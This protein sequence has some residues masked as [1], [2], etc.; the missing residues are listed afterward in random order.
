MKVRRTLRVAG[1]NVVLLVAGVVLTAA[2]LEVRL[3]L[4]V[5][6]MS[7]HTP[8]R[9]VSGVGLVRPPDAEIRYTNGLDFWTVSRTNRW[10]FL[11]REPLGLDRAA[12][13]CHVAVIGDS[14]VEAKEVSIA[15]KMH[16][17][18]EALVARRLPHLEATAAA[19][20]F[21]G[22][23]QVNQLPYYDA[24]ARRQRPRLVVLVFVDNDFAD[25]SALLDM[26]SLRRQVDPKH[27]PF[28]YAER[29]ADG[30]ITLRP[31]DPDW[32]EHVRPLSPAGAAVDRLFGASW[33]AQWLI[34]KRNALFPADLDVGERLAVLR[35]R[36]GG[37]RLR[38]WRP[39]PG[40]VDRTFA[41][42]ALPP[43][44]E[45]ALEFTA[46]ALEQ[47]KARAARDSA[48]LAI[49]ASHRMAIAG[50]RIFDRLRVLA[51]TLRIPVIDQ[52]DYILRQ[53]MRLE[54]AHWRHAPHWNIAGHRWAA[55]ALLEWLQDN[56]EVCG[57]LSAPG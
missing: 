24:Y 1:L 52:A 57:R 42:E 35:Q 34:A 14:F 31:P 26:F 2:V 21:G 7:P 54:D 5:P 16:V 44:F 43:A 50:D 11:D 25:N 6:F 17:R 4:T 22:T 41:D 12:S 3:R 15:D 13:G 55:E 56:Q 37:E 39:A 48:A 38:G 33:L 53:G 32:E 51:G 8:S 46:F 18:F 27:L 36:A 45:D 30:R 28:L 29:M 9:F 23:G 40:G 19:F 47:F 20:G 49:L 10:G